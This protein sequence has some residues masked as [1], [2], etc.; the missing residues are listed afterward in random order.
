MLLYPVPELEGTKTDLKDQSKA[1]EWV[2]NSLF[3]PHQL[4]PGL[5]VRL[6]KKNLPHLAEAKPNFNN[7]IIGPFY[8]TVTMTIFLF[9]IPYEA[10][11][12]LKLVLV[13]NCFEK[14]L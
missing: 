12:K 3:S 5:R 8:I 9:G 4:F 13:Q 14:V 6:H 11:L 1:F 7:S 2:T 10:I